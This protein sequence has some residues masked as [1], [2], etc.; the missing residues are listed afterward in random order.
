MLFNS[1]AYILV[2]LPLVAITYYLC[3]VYVSSL[4]SKLLLVLASL[5]FYGF[6][7]INYVPILVGSVS[8]NY[9]LVLLIMRQTRAPLR[10][11]ILVAGVFANLGLLVFF[12]YSNFLIA[13]INS[14]AEMDIRLLHIFVPLGISFYTFIQIAFL[15]D[16]YRRASKMCSF[17]DYITFST[18]FP[19]ILSGPIVVNKEI[20]PQLNGLEEKIDYK[21][22]TMGLILFFTGLF[23]KIIL[24]EPLAAWADQGFGATSLSFI[25]GWATSLSYTLQIY[26]DFSGYTDMALGSALILE[27]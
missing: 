27:H 18:F 16:V 15:A 5:F 10:K 21:L 8:F 11:L 9:L 26:F 4:A 20:A 14:A 13:T 7:N 12:K 3:R 2:F 22:I 19:Y 24:V 17:L 1:C 25:E 6:A 23:K